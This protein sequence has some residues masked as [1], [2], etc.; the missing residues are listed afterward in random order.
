MGDLGYNDIFN[1]GH[2]G[3]Q[4]L[5]FSLKHYSDGLVEYEKE[6]EKEDRSLK[7]FTNNW[8]KLELLNSIGEP[9]KNYIYKQESKCSNQN[10][11]DIT[12]VC[13]YSLDSLCFSIHV[14]EISNLVNMLKNNQ[15]CPVKVNI[16]NK[17]F[18]LLYNG[19]A[20]YKSNYCKY[21][22]VRIPL[23]TVTRY[24]QKSEKWTCKIICSHQIFEFE[25]SGNLPTAW[26]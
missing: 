3:K 24:L 6:K 10:K 26:C 11:I 16:Y 12:T 19:S 23:D 18:N 20:F 21:P 1:N 9:T 5:S 15:N 13:N 25:L 8:K 4:H 7:S 14:Q 17:N 22:I 2:Q